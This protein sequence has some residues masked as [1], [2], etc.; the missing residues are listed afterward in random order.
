[1]SMWCPICSNKINPITFEGRYL[2]STYLA[3]RNP[4]HEHYLPSTYAYGLNK[5]H[6]EKRAYK[7]FCK[8]YSLKGI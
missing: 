8:K 4:I 6:A 3:C 5:K 1:M 2:Y 7:K